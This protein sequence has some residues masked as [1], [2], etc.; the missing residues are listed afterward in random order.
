MTKNVPPQ[1]GRFR[2]KEE[3]GLGIRKSKRT[4]PY[5][6]INLTMSKREGCSS[7]LELLKGTRPGIFGVWTLSV[8]AVTWAVWLK[9]LGTKLKIL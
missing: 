5:W 6:V 4:S 9:L 3:G 1:L 2:S 8:N 7:G